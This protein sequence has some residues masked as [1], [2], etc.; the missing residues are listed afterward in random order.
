MLSTTAPS[1][2]FFELVKAIG[3]SR[4][5]QEEDKI[6]VNEKFLLK[7][8]LSE[9]NVTSKKMREYLIRAVYVEMLGHEASFAY[10]HAVNLTYDKSL[11][12]KRTGYLTCNIFLNCEHE[13][14]LLLINTIQRVCVC[15]FVSMY[16]CAYVCIPFVCAFFFIFNTTQTQ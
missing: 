14:M 5:K 9:P 15:V 6:I 2:E 3:E 10:I 1:K 12:C 13:L 16:V 11:L 4:S 7:Q 8:R